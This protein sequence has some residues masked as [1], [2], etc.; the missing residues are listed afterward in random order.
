MFSVH[1]AVLVYPLRIRLK[2]F[3]FYSAKFCTFVAKYRPGTM[4]IHG[5]VINF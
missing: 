3:A 2:E 4:C 1:Q 5:T